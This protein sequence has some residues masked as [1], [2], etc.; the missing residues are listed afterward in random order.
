[1]ATDVFD[2]LQNERALGFLADVIDQLRDGGQIT[3]REDIMIYEA[4]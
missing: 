1:M 3:S 4:A 2:L